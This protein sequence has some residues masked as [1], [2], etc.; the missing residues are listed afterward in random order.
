MTFFIT[1]YLVFFLTIEKQCLLDVHQ[2]IADHVIDEEPMWI[3]M[4]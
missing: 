4:F 2:F 1:I 3:A